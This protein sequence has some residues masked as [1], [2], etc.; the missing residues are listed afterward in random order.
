MKNDLCID[1]YTKQFSS[2]IQVIPMVLAAGT[3]FVRNPYRDILAA[4]VCKQSFKS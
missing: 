4:I 2:F 3:L 1:F